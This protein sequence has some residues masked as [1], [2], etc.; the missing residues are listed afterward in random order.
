MAEFSV[1]KSMFLQDWGTA[2][3]CCQ[4]LILPATQ[5]AWERRMNGGGGSCRTL[6]IHF[7]SPDLDGLKLPRQLCHPSGGLQQSDSRQQQVSTSYS[8]KCPAKQCELCR[9]WFLH[10]VGS[11]GLILCLAE[12]CLL[13]GGKQFHCSSPGEH[14]QLCSFCP[15]LFLT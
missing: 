5:I 3:Q 2:Y 9:L 1:L 12:G 8:D 4:H 15:V 7:Q 14:A 11:V 13:H 10:A 6:L